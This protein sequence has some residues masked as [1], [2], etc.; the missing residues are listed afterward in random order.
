[1]KDRK[2]GA[3]AVQTS[4]TV[5]SDGGSRERELRG[6][7][8]SLNDENQNG[9]DFTEEVGPEAFLEYQRHVCSQTSLM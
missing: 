3:P 9:L 4:D 7:W 1:M 8:T 2:G 5:G 6:K